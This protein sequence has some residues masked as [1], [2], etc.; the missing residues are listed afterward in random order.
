MM[1]L[2]RERGVCSLIT[3]EMRI[4]THELKQTSNQ[5]VT[6]LEL[7]RSCEMQTIHNEIN[8]DD[9]RQVY[10]IAVKKGTVN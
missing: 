2:T 10:Q 8:N 7:D 6:L 9:K 5:A 4:E 3:N 1:L